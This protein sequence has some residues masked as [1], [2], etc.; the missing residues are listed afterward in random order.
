MPGRYLFGPVD[1]HFAGQFLA[2]HRAA[3]NCRAFD[4]RDGPDLTI[5]PEEEIG[6]ATPSQV[7][8]FRFSFHSPQG[9]LEM[10]HRRWVG[11]LG[12]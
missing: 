3:G 4:L 8:K 5:A 9:T 11:D 2:P 1:A 6:R 7:A 12:L 10:A